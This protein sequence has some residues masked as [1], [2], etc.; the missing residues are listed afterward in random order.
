MMFTIY[1]RHGR[2]CWEETASKPTQ[3]TENDAG[4]RRWDERREGRGEEGHW[5]WESG[6]GR[7]PEVVYALYA[8]LPG[9][10]AKRGH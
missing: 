9:L 8:T 7:R 4:V 3:T 2:R 10:A 5:G 6:G 1:H